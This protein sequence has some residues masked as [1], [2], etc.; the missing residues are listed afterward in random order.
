MRLRDLETHQLGT[1]RLLECFTR[2]D[3]SRYITRFEKSFREHT[4]SDFMDY[5]RWVVRLY[6]A[7]KHV[8]GAA[9]FQC[10][11]DHVRDTGLGNL[12]SYTAYYAFHHAVCAVTTLLPNVRF[13]S[14]GIVRHQRCLN[15]LAHEVFPRQPQHPTVQ[16]MLTDYNHL[17]A[18]REAF[19]YRIPLGR[20][21]GSPEESA[22]LAL[23]RAKDHVGR[24]IQ[25]TNVL[26]HALHALAKLQFPG[27][28][29]DAQYSSRGRAMETDELLFSV[30]DIRDRMGTT[31]W[32][33]DDDYRRLGQQFYK[34]GLV[35]IDWFIIEKLCEDLECA[36]WE[37]DSTSANEGH[38]EEFSIRDVS[39]YLSSLMA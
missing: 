5:C 37:T 39:R 6:R 16:E 13:E 21:G 35:P 15:V 18:L 4:G 24:L 38:N 12:E 30:L 22:R 25:L 27:M 32:M 36:W 26:S 9:L 19:S 8:L 23:D 14:L 1:L 17:L 33:D 2:D 3:L 20:L 11:A 34:R 28:D 31:S 29:F 7:A 10:E